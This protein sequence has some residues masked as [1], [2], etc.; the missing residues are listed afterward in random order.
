MR[1]SEHPAR[2]AHPRGRAAAQSRSLAVLGAEEAERPA[3]LLAAA[4]AL[5]LLGAPPRLLL[6]ARQLVLDLQRRQS[7]QPAARSPSTASL[8]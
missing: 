7:A 4:L 8:C 5:G 2:R 1:P 3:A 6:R